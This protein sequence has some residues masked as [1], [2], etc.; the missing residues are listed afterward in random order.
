MRKHLTLI[1]APEARIPN[2]GDKNDISEL[3]KHDW[4][5]FEYSWI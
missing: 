4:H 2:V 5:K 1:M 3:S